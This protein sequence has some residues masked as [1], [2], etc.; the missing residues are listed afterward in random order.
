MKR[1]VI[2]LLLFLTPFFAL[3][4]K[5]TLIELGINSK[6]IV[7]RHKESVNQNS[8]LRKPSDGLAKKKMISLPFFDDFSQ[9]YF[10]PDEN[11]WEDNYVFINSNYAVNPISYGVATFDGLDSIGYPYD[12]NNPTAHGV[13]DYLTSKSIDLSTITDS[14]FLSFY[15]QPQGYGN[16][17]ETED[18]LKLEFYRPSDSTWVRKWAAGG[19]AT[20]P[21]QRVMVPV[22]TSFHKTDFKFRFK[23]Y[24]TLSGN[25]DHWNLDYIYLNDN[26]THDD[27]ITYDVAITGDFYNFLNEYTAMPW[28]HYLVDT[29]NYM[30][31]SIDVEY[32]NNYN[33]PFAVFYKY[34]VIDNNGA[35]PII[36]T[37]PS[38]TSSKN[39]N[40]HSSLIEPQAVY[41]MPANDFY[42]PVESSAQTKVFQIKNYFDLNTLTDDHQENDTVLSYQVFG[43]DYAY[44]DGSAEIG[45]GVQGV[46]SKLAHQFNFKK[47]DTLTAFKIYF[48][49]IR[50]NLSAKTFKLTIWNSL[51]PENIIYQQ[52]AYYSPIYSLTNEFL[53]YNLDFPL[54]LPAGTYYIGWEKISEEF[55]NV[56]WDVNHNNSSKVF[57]NAVGVWENATKSGSLMLRPVFGT[58]P[59]PVVNVNEITNDESNIVVYPNPVNNLV[60]YKS[61]I[62]YNID[63]IDLLGKSIISINSSKD[64]TI[65]VS[66][67]KNGIYFLRFSNENSVHTKKIIV[68][69]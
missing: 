20:M 2:Y 39:V 32:R 53:Y 17:P 24:A 67:L 12:F 43:T 33:T 62:V 68:S 59:E 61:D 54:Y 34:Q 65:D 66:T 16:K 28:Q 46:G 10:Y 47:S 5:D 6:L 8:L 38:T 25:V 44:D 21:F 45:Y 41:N 57:F 9:H 36:E 26:R 63:V 58:F 13:A 49:P 29:L 52:N 18:S 15:Y 60:H 56:G 19:S 14:V 27:T 51:A 30:S 4:Q 50:D 11:K 40:A 3:A 31:S 48:S 37:Y 23:N 55:L 42:F 7:E 22:D 1:T 35:G 69:K 64:G